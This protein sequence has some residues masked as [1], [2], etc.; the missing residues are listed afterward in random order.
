MR[1]LLSKWDEPRTY[2]RP[3]ERGKVL[4]VGIVGHL[5]S[6]RVSTEKG[7]A[8]KEVRVKLVSILSE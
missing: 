1:S 2:V 6:D 7:L 3:E 5:E 8:E 4:E